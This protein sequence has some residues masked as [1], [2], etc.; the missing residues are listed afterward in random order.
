MKW[1]AISKTKDLGGWR[2]TNIHQ[3]EK[4]LA[5]MDFWRLIT[6]DGL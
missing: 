3:F 5:V 1:K 4:A 6:N 2:L